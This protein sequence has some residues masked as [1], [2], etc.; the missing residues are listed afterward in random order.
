MTGPFGAASFSVIFDN[1]V[2]MKVASHC[3][4]QFLRPRGGVVVAN[5]YRARKS[6]RKVEGGNVP[7]VGWKTGAI[8]TMTDRRRATRPCVV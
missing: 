2:V 3:L 5:F 8:V 1:L 7:P 4:S 6:G